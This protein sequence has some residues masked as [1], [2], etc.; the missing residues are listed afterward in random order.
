MMPK[1][2]RTRAQNRADRLAT[3]RSYNRKVRKAHIA[4]VQRR[5]DAI[6]IANDE[7]RPF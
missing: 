7:P 5:E 4:E 1:R 2:R 6:I 3:E